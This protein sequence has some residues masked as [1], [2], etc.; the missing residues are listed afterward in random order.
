MIVNALDILFL[1]W[2]NGLTMKCFHCATHIEDDDYFLIQ[3]KSY[4]PAGL[5][6]HTTCF[7]SIAGKQFGTTLE[8]GNKLNLCLL[9]GDVPAISRHIHTCTEC[10]GKSPQCSVCQTPTMLRVNRSK[11][12]LF[13]G[14]ANWPSCKKTISIR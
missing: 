4:N 5:Y 14:C 6:F 12:G 13:W 2:Y 3:K 10:S 9:C 1:W 11:T 8:R 7:E